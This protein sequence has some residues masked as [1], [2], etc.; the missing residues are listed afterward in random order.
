MWALLSKL[1]F[2]QGTTFLLVLFGASIIAIT[3][4]IQAEEWL[5]NKINNTV[6]ARTGRTIEQLEKQV[7]SLEILVRKLEIV[8]AGIK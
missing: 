5:T 6:E 4:T 2:S 7:N 1:R 3:T 8:L